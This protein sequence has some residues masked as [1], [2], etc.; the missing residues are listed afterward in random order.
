VDPAIKNGA[1][2]RQS[3]EA[4]RE[5]R[6]VLDHHL[7]LGRALADEIADDRQS[8]GDADT[9]FE[10]DPRGRP[11]PRH[12][13]DDVERRPH[14]PLR[15]ILMRVR[16]TEIDQ[17]S[18]AHVFRHEAAVAINVPVDGSLEDR[19]YLTDVLRIHAGRKG[20]RFDDIA[21]HHS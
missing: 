4:G 2:L 20:G 7:F 18:I 13:R 1:G 21:K 14:C 8:S 16:I 19:N 15:V 12:C 10:L 9:Y 17:H 5:V 6:R 3:L 11:D